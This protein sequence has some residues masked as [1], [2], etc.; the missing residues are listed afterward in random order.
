MG[1]TE[2]TGKVQTVL[3]IIDADN[4]GVTLPHEH[5]SMCDL[6]SFF[7]V[8]P[9]EVIEKRLAHQPL[10]LETLYWARLHPANH[11]DSFKPMDE[12]LFIKEVLLYKQAGGNTIVDLTNNRIGRDPLGSAR[13][14]R[15]T[16]LNVIIGSG[17]YKAS[18]HPPELATKTEEEI[19]E[20]IVGEIMVGVGDT[21]VRA[22]IIGE[23]GCS[24]PLADNERKVVRASAAAQRRTGAAINIHPSHDED[25]VM[26]T[27]KILGDA[28]ADLSRT[29]ISHCQFS[30]FNRA[31]WHKIAEAGCYLEFDI[32][33]QFMNYPLAQDPAVLREEHL[34]SIR[35]DVDNINEI[36]GLIDEGYLNHILIS[37]DICWKHHYVTYGGAGYAHILRNIVPWMRRGGISDEQI[38]TMMVENP[39]RYLPFAPV[40][41]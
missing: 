32:F 12:K 25:L 21:G 34:I 10:T 17:Y 19:T 24:I 4:L 1:E 13:I 40:K 30:P 41:E 39:K 16:G 28:G 18:Y 15:A 22:G 35:S 29:V 7:F 11:L 9:T 14:A 27:I 31:T 5:L 6:S 8:E 20:E 38:H 23:I 33:G 3:G 36:K 2:L 37:H 26:E